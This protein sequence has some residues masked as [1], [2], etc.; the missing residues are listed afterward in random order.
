MN[1][2]IV[3]G[4]LA[5]L[6]LLFVTAAL[7]FAVSVRPLRLDGVKVSARPAPL[8]H[9]QGG[10]HATCG[11]CHRVGGEAM[12]PPRTH[13][14]FSLNTCATCH[15]PIL[16]GS[17]RALNRAPMAPA[18]RNGSRPATMSPMGFLVR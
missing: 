17:G 12:A 4:V 10:A 14:Q 7:L 13:V 3:S 11:G 18:D 1:H 16:Q 5:L 6:L 2:R 9:E 15:P 8:P